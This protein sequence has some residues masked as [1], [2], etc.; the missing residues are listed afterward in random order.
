VP[1]PFVSEPAVLYV[2]A[3]IAPTR[4]STEIDSEIYEQYAE[5][6]A[7]GARARLYAQPRQ[8]YTDKAAALD[9]TKMFR[10][11]INRIRMQ[12]TKGLTRG[13]PR[14]EFQRWV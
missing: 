6:I 5:I 13:S 3:A 11:E 4:D 10:F 9:A 2:K 8:D 14:V 1:T 7:W 12:V